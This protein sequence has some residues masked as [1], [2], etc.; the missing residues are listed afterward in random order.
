MQHAISGSTAPTRIVGMLHVEHP[1]PMLLPGTVAASFLE[2]HPQ[3]VV[4]GC[5]ALEVIY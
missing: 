1:N 4:L 3:D 2:S 5:Q